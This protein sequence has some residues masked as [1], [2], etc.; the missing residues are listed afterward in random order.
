MV[1]VSMKLLENVPIMV[2]TADSDDTAA[3]RTYSFFSIGVF[4]AS[5]AIAQ[6]SGSHPFD[7]ILK[8]KFP[9]TNGCHVN[10]SDS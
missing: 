6:L 10:P 5:S 8:Q 3:T 4:G 9:P 7:G 2:I 1:V